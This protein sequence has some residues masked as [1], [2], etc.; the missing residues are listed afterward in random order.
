MNVCAQRNRPER[1]G[2]TDVR[3]RVI[4]GRYLG[5]N[6]QTVRR[7]NVALLAIA[8]F[9]QCDSRGPIRIVLDRGDLGGDADLATLEVDQPVAAL[10]AAA[11][12]ARCDATTVVATAASFFGSVKLLTGLTAFWSPR[13]IG[14]ALKRSAG[15]SGRKFLKGITD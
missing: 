3:R 14:S 5:A 8:V 13:N 2:V 6:L 4:A 15:V 10:V 7:E 1:Q 12:E 9:D 11:A